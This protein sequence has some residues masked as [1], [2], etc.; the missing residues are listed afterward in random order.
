LEDLKKK[1]ILDYS[2]YERAKLAQK[3]AFKEKEP[4]MPRENVKI[5]NHAKKANKNL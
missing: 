1:K 4:E 2:E 3:D 5:E